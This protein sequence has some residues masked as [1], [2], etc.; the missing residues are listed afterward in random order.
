M[1]ASTIFLIID[2]QIKLY[3][4]TIT[5]DAYLRLWS[6]VIVLLPSVIF[7]TIFIANKVESE[8]AKLFTGLLLLCIFINIP[9]TLAVSRSISTALRRLLASFQQMQQSG[10]SITPT[11]W[12]PVK[13]TSLRPP[14][15]R[16]L[17]PFSA[18]AIIWRK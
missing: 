12:L 9:L 14:L 2:K 17:I 6:I 10:Y 4:S 16:W 15:I 3:L 7:S 5:F 8:K 11:R 18:N 13:S 1:K